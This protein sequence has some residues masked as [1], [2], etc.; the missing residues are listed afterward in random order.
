MQ[1]IYNF[2]A[3][4]AMLPKVVL[5][6]AQEELCDWHGTGMSVMEMSHRDKDFTA[7]REKTEHTLRELL[8]IPKHYHVLFLSGGATSQ[9]AMV[10]MNLLGNK[11]KA[12]YIHSGQ[13]S[14]KAME[15]AARYAA[16]DVLAQVEQR[17]GIHHLPNIN[18]LPVTDEH[19]YFYYTDNETISGMQF[20]YLPQTGNVPLVSDMTS[21]ILSKPLDIERYGLIYASAQKN[22]GHAGVT[23][24]IV[25]DDC[26]KPVQEYTPT[27]FR[28]QIHIDNQSCYNTPP[29]Y[30]WYFLGLMLD[31]V[32]QQG[33]VSVMQ[34]QCQQKTKR[35]YELLDNHDFYQSPIAPADRSHLNVP[36]TLAKP[37]LEGA[38]LEQAKQAGLVGL[39]GHRSVGG[40]RASIYLGMPEAGVKKLV[41][42]MQN[43]AEK[44]K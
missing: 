6:Q 28:Y 27:M 22:L 38:F 34:Q 11:K 20:H 25:R 14:K 43:F 2:S 7:I 13:W 18:D 16:V 5:Q 33:G 3:G 17:N 40:M 4:P 44:N 8:A 1:N 9:F 32:K 15:E 23:V 41:E 12:A 24:V 30:A 37:V 29:T 10:P 31:W 19:A 39:T 26:V 42:F 21:S 35:L 36:F